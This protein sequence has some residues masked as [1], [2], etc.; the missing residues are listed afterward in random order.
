MKK[1]ICRQR[2]KAL[3]VARA[4][5][6]LP[7]E[8]IVVDNAS[9]DGTAA[10][11]GALGA[12]VVRHNVRNISSVR[13][14]GI[15]AAAYDLIVS[16]DADCFTPPHALTRIHEFMS[17]GK[18]VGGGLGLRVLTD[19][20]LLRAAASNVQGLTERLGGIRGAVFFFLKEDALAIGGFDET[21]LVA[22][23][24]TFAQAMHKRAHSRGLKFGL[25]KDVEITTNDRKDTTVLG[26]LKM[27]P[28]VWRV[29]RGGVVSASELGYWYD[30]KR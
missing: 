23:D 19:K 30:P 12:R 15:G 27:A 21:K 13:N 10:V 16:I 18:H 9:T 8:V 20:I 14:A 7:S 25:L 2:S 26:L 1:N 28:R 29:Y 4:A 6:H 3:R 24:T 11:A 5:F 22:E 17:G